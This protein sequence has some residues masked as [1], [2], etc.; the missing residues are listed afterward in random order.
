M[1]SAIETPTSTLRSDDRSRAASVSVWQQKLEVQLAERL[2]RHIPCAEMICLRRTGIDATSEAIRLTQTATRRDRIILCGYQE[3]REWHVGPTSHHLGLPPSG[4]SDPVHFGDLKEAARLFEQHPDEIAAIILEPA[5]TTEPPEGYLRGV[6]ELA[7]RYGAL[8]IFDE[9]VTGYRWSIGGAQAHYA[10]TPDLAC[11]G[12]AMANGMPISAIVGR[13]DVMRVAKRNHLSSTFEVETLSIAAAIATLDKLER[14]NVAGR[15][16]QLGGELMSA[17]QGKIGAARLDQ[18]VRLIGAPACA[19]LAYRD[20][21]KAPKE[22]IRMLLLRELIAAGVLV[23]R[24][25]NLCFAHTQTDIAR[26]L[27]AYEHALAVLREALERGD[28][29]LRLRNQE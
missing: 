13:A 29:E 3:P 9:I 12:Q 17:V 1:F 16:W 14:E 2:M 8:V 7:H 26:V 18:V 19:T 6:V 27:A 22:A 4:P 15:L 24:S 25:H 11:F 21:A 5:G 28:V 10:V 23:E 20:H